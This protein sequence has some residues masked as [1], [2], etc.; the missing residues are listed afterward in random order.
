M[1]TMLATALMA[2]GLLFALAGC[3]GQNYENA[4]GDSEFALAAFVPFYF[5]PESDA[6]SRK[7]EIA[8]APLATVFING[9]E[10]TAESSFHSMLMLVDGALFMQ[11]NSF[12]LTG[13]LMVAR[14]WWIEDEEV[15][16]WPGPG[17]PVHLFGLGQNVRFN[18]GSPFAEIFGSDGWDNPILFE[19]DAAPFL[20]DGVPMLPVRST[21]E[22]FGA[23]AEWDGEAIVI[24]TEQ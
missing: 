5:E 16:E 24:W 2:F 3:S 8:C 21:F 23:L 19:M 12:D 22:A 15:W 17:K 13:P 7:P 14:N 4:Q 18:I 10:L 20:L 11:Y 6:V 1:R 9:V